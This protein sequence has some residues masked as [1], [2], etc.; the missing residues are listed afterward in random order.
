MTLKKKR[1][2]VTAILLVTVLAFAVLIPARPARAALQIHWGGVNMNNY[3][4]IHYSGSTAV[5]ISP[6]NAYTWRC[7][8]GAQYYQISVNDACRHQY[9]PQ[10]FARTDHP[11]S[12]WSWECYSYW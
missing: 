5:N 6:Y 2:L 7:R 4:S 11:E 10:A 12:P 8:I 1:L 9:V 3:C